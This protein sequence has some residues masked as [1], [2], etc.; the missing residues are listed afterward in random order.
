MVFLS[1]T[2]AMPIRQVEHQVVSS[3]SQPMSNAE[4]ALPSVPP[5]AVLR[6]EDVY[7]RQVFIGAM[8]LIF[9]PS[10]GKEQPPG[11]DGYNTSTIAG[12]TIIFCR[13]SRC[14]RCV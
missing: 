6:S 1:N 12:R 14:A 13:F 2:S 10:S 7:K 4:F 3:L 11:T 8:W 5:M 9:A